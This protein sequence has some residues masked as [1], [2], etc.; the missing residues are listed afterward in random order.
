MKIVSKIAFCIVSL[1]VLTLFISEGQPVRAYS[2]DHA[3]QK[4]EFTPEAFKC[5]QAERYFDAILSRVNISNIGLSTKLPSL[6]FPTFDFL[7]GEWTK[8]EFQ[9]KVGSPYVA[10][11]NPIA[12]R[13]DRQSNYYIYA[14]HR[15][16]I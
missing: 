5:D 15:I 6:S 12:Y 8:N 1:F 2:V 14:L 4:C 10:N 9:P 11:Q 16:R 13:Y 3:E 7:T